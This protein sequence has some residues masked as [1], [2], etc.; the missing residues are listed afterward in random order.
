MRTLRERCLDEI[1]NRMATV[2]EASPGPWSYN[3]YS[4]IASVPLLK[5][6][7]PWLIPLVDADHSLERNERCEPCGKNGCDLWL[8]DYL[9][10]DPVVAST[11]AMHGDMARYRHAE[12]AKFIEMHNPADALLRYEADLDRLDWHG[13]CSDDPDNPC[14][15]HANSLECCFCGTYGPCTEQ[16]RVA[17]SLHVEAGE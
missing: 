2:Q 16:R 10:R 9:D 1:G 5:A 15:A 8:E 4:M 11:P 13:P 14:A 17:S 3:G 12:D 6:Y 7:D